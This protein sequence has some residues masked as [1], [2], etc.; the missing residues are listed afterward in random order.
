MQA[1]WSA[2]GTVSP[3]Q[4]LH[5][6]EASLA[7]VLPAHASQ[8]EFPAVA[9]LPAGHAVHEARPSDETYPSS[10]GTQLWTLTTPAVRLCKPMGQSSQS[11]AVTWPADAEARMYVPDAHG[12]QTAWPGALE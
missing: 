8:L 10:H 6:P 9:L 1:L 12:V 2:V 4:G 5:E 11:A 3:S 7:K